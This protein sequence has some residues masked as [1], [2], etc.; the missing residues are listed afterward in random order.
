MS[1][2][3]HVLKTGILFS[4]IN[5][6][7]FLCTVNM[8]ILNH[9][10]LVDHHYEYNKFLCTICHP[11]S[12]MCACCYRPI[13]YERPL[14]LCMGVVCGLVTAHSYHTRFSFPNLHMSSSTVLLA[15]TYCDSWR[16]RST[17]IKHAEPIV[18]ML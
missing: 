17:T 7:S 9:K 15:A 6:L 2:I 8:V 14:G 16:A 12:T 5:H 18:Y 1:L 13:Q 10:F 3:V 11:P 4:K